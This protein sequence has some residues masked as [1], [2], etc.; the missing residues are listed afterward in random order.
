MPKELTT[1]EQ[2]DL[3]VKSMEFPTLGKRAKV[4]RNLMYVKTALGGTFIPVE[5]KCNCPS[6]DGAC[7]V[8]DEYSEEGGTCAT[9]FEEHT[10]WDEEEKAYYP[11]RKGERV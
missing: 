4:K 5:Q 7:D 1:E 10:Y 8:V 9:C 2:I 6:C 11:T 3:I